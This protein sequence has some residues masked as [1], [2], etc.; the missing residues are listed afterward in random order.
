[1]D[2]IRFHQGRDSCY[3]RKKSLRGPKTLKEI[4]MKQKLVGTAIAIGLL[5]AC[6]S[7]QSIGQRT[8]TVD[9]VV[10]TVDANAGHAVIPT[11]N[12]SLDGPTHIEAESDGA[13]KFAFN[14]VPPGVY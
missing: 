1:M 14:A 5:A 9:G 4:N 13:G 3:M 8:G 12:I 2:E 7:A 6:V 10:Y 11:A